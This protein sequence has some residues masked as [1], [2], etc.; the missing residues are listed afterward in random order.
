M[1]NGEWEPDPRVVD[2]ISKV[3]ATTG[4]Y[5]CT[6][7]FPQISYYSRPQALPPFQCSKK[8]EGLGTRLSQALITVNMADWHE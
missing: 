5:T 4:E 3:H 1:W 6:A 8:W 2:C 7:L